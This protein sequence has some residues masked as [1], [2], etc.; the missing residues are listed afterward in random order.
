MKNI[1]GVSIF[2]IYT[3]QQNKWE[4]KCVFVANILPP[5]N[6]LSPGYGRIYKIIIG[7]TKNR[8]QYEVK[9]GEFPYLQ[10][11]KICV[12]DDRLIGCTWQVGAS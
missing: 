3:Q 11:H 5:T 4:A 9:I 7:P 1:C 2:K 12:N 6:V 8:K 10:L